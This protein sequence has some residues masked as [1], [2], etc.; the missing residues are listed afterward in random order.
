[1]E[2][3]VGRLT[4]PCWGCRLIPCIVG[5]AADPRMDCTLEILRGDEDAG[6]VEGARRCCN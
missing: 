1:M 3:P 4:F 6:M 2:M 5:E